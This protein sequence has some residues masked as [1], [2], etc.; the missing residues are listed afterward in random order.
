MA[1]ALCHSD[2]LLSHPDEIANFDFPQQAVALQ[3]FRRKLMCYTGR[4]IFY[5]DHVRADLHIERCKS[6]DRTIL[7]VIHDDIYNIYIWK[8]YII[9]IWYIKNF[10]FHNSPMKCFIANIWLL[11]QMSR[12]AA[13]VTDTGLGASWILSLHSMTPENVLFR[14][15]GMTPTLDYILS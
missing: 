5:S 6:V 3:C 4:D 1:D 9:G 15:R 11:S 8:N 13:W 2:D 12:W 7:F 10:I 14:Y